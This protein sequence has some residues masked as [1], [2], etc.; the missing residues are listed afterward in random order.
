M[1]VNKISAWFFGCFIS[2]MVAVSVAATYSTENILDNMTE[3]DDSIY[4]VYRTKNT[5]N[6]PRTPGVPRTPESCSYPVITNGAMHLR[7]G[8][9][10]PNRGLIWPGIDLSYEWSTTSGRGELGF[11]PYGYAYIWGSDMVFNQD[12]TSYEML[13]SM[14]SDSEKG[15][16]CTFYSTEDIESDCTTS[17]TLFEPEAG[18]HYAYGVELFRGGRYSE[19]AKQFRRAI[20]MNPGEKV[21]PFAYVQSLFALADYDQ[22]TEVLREAVVLVPM[23]ESLLYNPRELY[24]DQA[25]LAEQVARLEGM[26]TQTSTK[27]D[28]QLLLGYQ[29]LVLQDFDRA[30]RFLTE[31]SKKPLNTSAAQRLL[32]LAAIS[33]HKELELH[34]AQVK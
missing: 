2:V 17:Q 11:W 27:T 23:N 7:P 10:L 31:A 16:T 12:W 30:F 28:Y 5:P 13:S 34:E 32:E 25:V 1:N 21:L 3:A 19:A 33:R 9:Y 14:Y 20:L 8:P 24:N 4:S 29:C 15:N 26:M 18:P 6:R 22:A